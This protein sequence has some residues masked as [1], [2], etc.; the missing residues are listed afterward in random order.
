MPFDVL[1]WLRWGLI[2]IGAIL[3][4]RLLL[5]TSDST[6]RQLIKEIVILVAAFAAYFA[7]RAVAEG[8]TQG[9]IH[10]AKVIEVERT[11]GIFWEPALQ[12]HILDFDALVVFVNWVYVWGHW[13][14]IA[15][16]AVWLFL[17]NRESYHVYRNAFVIS[18]AIGLIV[19]VLFPV[20]PPRLLDAS[21]GF[22]DTVAQNSSAYQV[23][24]PP[25]FVNQYAAMPSLHFGWSLL[26]GIGLVQ[27][28]RS[29]SMQLLG[30][31]M[32]MAMFTSI[33]LTANH[34]I[35]DGLAGGILAL[36]GLAVALLLHQTMKRMDG[37]IRVPAFQ[38]ALVR[39]RERTP[40]LSS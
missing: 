7:V 34:Y 27:T 8:Q 20:A 16:A 35:I 39:V 32:P 22:V 14:F 28:A 36:M 38:T 2:A 3:L 13:P 12:A 23:L 4:I 9:F 15:M 26:V 6:P 18:G 37:G 1:V 10:A 11:L 19:Y 29:R 24:Q 30:F 33:V 21:L 5:P 25:A 17:T 31:F 40:F